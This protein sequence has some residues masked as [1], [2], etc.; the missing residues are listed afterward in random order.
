MSKPTREARLSAAFVAV[1]D[2]LIADFD[3]VDLLHTLVENCSE[4]LEVDA[5]GIMIVDEA[6]QLQ[7]VASTSEETSLVEIMQLAAGE[8]PCLDCFATGHSVTVA[9]IA[10]S[11]QQ[12]PAF[13]AEALRQGFNSVHAT[14]MR[15]RGQILGTMNLFGKKATILGDEDKAVAQALADV[16]TIGLL[17]E[18][19]IRES[20]VF[21]GQLQRALNSRIIIEQAKG[22]VSENAGLSMHES[23]SALR[24]YARD[25]NL[26][27]GA[28]ASSVV[29]RSL[30]VGTLA[31]TKPRP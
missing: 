6:G 13:S 10:K 1:A 5:G 4:I 2:T 14:P 28:V 25:H 19:A 21:T 26:T 11:A 16:A 15:L 30:N 7:L 24:T 17:Q 23:F 3:V 20:G 31:P 8:G 22:V 9:D 18:R 27:L 12:W 29:N